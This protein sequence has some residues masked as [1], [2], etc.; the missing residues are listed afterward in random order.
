MLKQ[1]HV[2][3]EHILTPKFDATVVTLA[4]NSTWQAEVTFSSHARED[5][6]GVN[7]HERGCLEK[8]KR[9]FKIK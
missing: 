6:E 1:L 2:A 7:Y 8:R 9:R 3:A 4:Y 5:E